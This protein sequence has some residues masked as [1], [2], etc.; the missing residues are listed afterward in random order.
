M[1]K[2]MSTKQLIYCAMAIALA[3]LTS[4]IKLFEMPMGGSVTLC[5]MLFIVLI[6]YWFGIGYGLITGLALGLLNYVI[7]PYFLSVPQVILDYFL[8]FA[9]LGVSGLFRKGKYA[10][11]IGYVVAIFARF[12][13]SA[14][15][16]ILFFAEYAEGSGMS[17]L[18]YTICYN[19]SY[20]GVE[21]IITLIVI[22]IPA[23]TNALNKVKREI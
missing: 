4:N 12:I 6:G 21:G 2:K 8:A 10:L 1:S 13:C 22:S 23:V 9:A 19:G 14:L 16:G 15:S 5:S 7:E 17:P 11:Q 20:I 18:I 3:F